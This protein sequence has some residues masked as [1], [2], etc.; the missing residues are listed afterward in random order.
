MGDGGENFF[1]YF[2]YEFVCG[3]C[4]GGDF[5]DEWFVFGVFGI[6]ECIDCL[7]EF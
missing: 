3:Y 1:V 4:M 6:D 7:V 2:Q 5:G